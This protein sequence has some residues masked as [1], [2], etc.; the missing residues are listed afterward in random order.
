VLGQIGFGFSVIPL[1]IAFDDCCHS[2]LEYGLRPILVKAASSLA[3]PR[4][5]A[6]TTALRQ[7]LESTTIMRFSK[8]G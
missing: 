4:S 3:T 8:R 2:M 1:K 7:G 5:S 6:Q